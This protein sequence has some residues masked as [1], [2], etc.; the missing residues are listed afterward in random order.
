MKILLI[1]HGDPDYELDSLTQKGWREAELLAMRLSRLD[2][3]AIYCSPL[4]RARDT[5]AP[6]L[7]KLGR[8]AT[9]LPWLTEFSGRVYPPA[10]GPPRIPWNFLPQYWTRCPLFF[11]KDHWASHDLMRTGPVKEI[12]D[13][14]YRGV[15]EL[16]AGHGYTK[17]GNLWQCAEG[18][19]DT[20][21]LFG[22]KGL[23]QV[24]MGYLLGVAAPVLWHSFYL[25]PAS[26]S[27]LI[28]E[29]RVKGTASFRCIASGD[30]SHLYAGQEAISRAGLY[31]EQAGN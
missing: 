25:P 17:D 2:I 27:C 16:L 26:I 29:E 22:H 24:I 4:G 12:L 23:S 1:R 5:A 7:A 28:T 10:G 18:T 13:Q 14:T 20:I 19:S 30:T 15:D 11:D 6:T 8:T 21:V 9:I 3:K 31:L